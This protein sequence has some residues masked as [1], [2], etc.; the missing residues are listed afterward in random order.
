ME[1]GLVIGI[2]WTLLVPILVNGEFQLKNVICES[3]DTSIS[4]FSRCEMKVVSRGVAAFFMVWKLYKIP[5]DNVG[6]NVSLYKK[7]NGYRPYLF[8]QTLDFCYYMRN[9]RAHPLI[10]M[11]HNVFLSTSNMNHSC[12]YNHDLIINNFIYK[13][14][15]LKDL[16]IPNG[17]YMIQ[18]NVAT[19]KAYRVSIKI[20][21]TR[22]G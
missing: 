9:P 5:I 3:F 11:M 21:A 18:V 8:N 7:S 15:D 17:D 13:Q 14:N 2:C 12:P 22:N 6:I 4:D 16:P 19:D 10:Y 1:K 20:Y